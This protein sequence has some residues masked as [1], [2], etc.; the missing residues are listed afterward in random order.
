MTMKEIE[1]RRLELDI[2]E[3]KLNKEEVDAQLR[4]DERRNIINSERIDLDIEMTE[5]ELASLKEI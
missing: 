4:F 3:I 5:I 1:I 2:E